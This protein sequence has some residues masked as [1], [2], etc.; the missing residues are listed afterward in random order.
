MAPY[1]SE[2]LAKKRKASKYVN[3]ANQSPFS[4]P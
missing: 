4:L 3:E 1:L 2:E